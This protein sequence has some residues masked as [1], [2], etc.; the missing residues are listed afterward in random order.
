MGR[1]RTKVVDTR[2]PKHGLDDNRPSSTKKGTRDAATVRRLKMYSKKATRDKKGK[3][4]SQDFQSKELPSTRIQPDRRWFGNTRVV[5]QQQLERFRSEMGAKAGDAYTVLLRQKKLPT[6]LLEDPEQKQ[7]EGGRAARSHLLTTQPFA[8]TFG[9]N[10]QRKRPRLAAESYGELLETSGR[11]S[12]KYVEEQADAPAPAWEGEKDAGRMSVFEKGQSKRIWG[13]LYKVLDS[14][15]VVIQVL[16]ARDPQGTRCGHLERHLRKTARHKHLILLLNKCDLVP[17]WVT[18]RWLAHLSKDF[19]TLAFHASVTNPFGKG[20]LLGLLRQLGRLHSD[21]KFVSVGFIGYPNVGKSSVINTLRT[22]KV[23]KV[24]PVPGETKVWQYIT[25]TKRIFLIDC[26]GV[27][28]KQAGDTDTDAVLKGVSR[29][30][31]LDEATEHVAAILERIKPAYLTRAYKV[32]QWEDATDF[33]TQVARASGKLARGGEPDT[34]T[35]ARMVLLDWQ[36][37]KLPFFHLPPDYIPDSAMRQA[38][39][40]PSTTHNNDDAQAAAAEAEGVQG[41][42][43]DALPVKQGLF[44]PGDEAAP[45][46]SPS[47][48]GESAEDASEAEDASPSS[49]SDADSDSKESK[50]AAGRPVGKHRA[51]RRREQSQQ[52]ADADSDTDSDGFEEG[53]LSWEAVMAS[54]KAEQAKMNQQ[55]AP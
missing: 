43:V 13:E 44:L 4:I 25:L 48:S 53:D 51:K 28:S 15:D 34:N 42:P 10:Q 7:R 35:A 33:L 24:A 8:S 30:E 14:S 21:K 2:K 38:A 37:G 45:A 12:D 22:K 50:Q 29:I 31:K 39:E 26:P 49:S 18:K 11:S 3:I 55:S 23:C 19:P 1:V 9:R 52:K 32:K 40:A 41:Q 16:D 20:S 17:A 47:Q 27:V 46:A 5:G 54:V 36:R 6:S